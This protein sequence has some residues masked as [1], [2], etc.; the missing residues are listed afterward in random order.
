[1]MKGFTAL[2]A[3][4]VVSARFKGSFAFNAPPGVLTWC[5]KAYEP[6]YVFLEFIDTLGLHPM[7]DH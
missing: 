1:M 5:G 2:L 3:A 4:L 7:I 6:T